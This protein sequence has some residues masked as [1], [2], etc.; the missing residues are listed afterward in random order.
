[1]ALMKSLN[2]SPDD[3]NFHQMKNTH[4]NLKNMTIFVEKTHNPNLT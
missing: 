2:Q 4:G 3:S 1:M